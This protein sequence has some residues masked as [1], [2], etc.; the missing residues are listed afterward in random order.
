MK[1]A[2]NIFIVSTPHQTV[3][4]EVR[5]IT[6]LKMNGWPHSVNAYVA[7][8]EGTT[9]GVIHGLDPHTMPEALKANLCI[10]TQGVEIVQA[11]MFKNTKTAVITFFGGSTPCSDDEQ[12]ALDH[13]PESPKTRPRFGSRYRSRPRSRTRK[14]S[15][16]KT[17]PRFYLHKSPK[18]GAPRSAIKQ[19]PEH[20]EQWETLLASE[21]LGVQ[22]APLNQAQRAAKASGALE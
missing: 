10:R 9:K 18:S 2:S 14:D 5:G 13:C 3:A 16:H 22:L 15:T 4:D 11:R 17:P 12:S 21:D 20:G 1:Q 6:T 7:A 19:A 8:S